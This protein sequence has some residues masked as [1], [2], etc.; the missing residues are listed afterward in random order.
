MA[1]SYFKLFVYGLFPIPVILLGLLI[2][3]LPRSVHKV[4]LKLTDSVLF[5]HPHPNLKISLYWICL[6]ISLFTMFTSYQSYDDKKFTYYNIKEHGGSSDT[7]L[8]KLLG[9]ERNVWIATTGTGLWFLLHRFRS[10]F[11]KL[12]LAEDSMK[13]QKSK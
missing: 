9:A 6:L 13:A 3:P 8:M 5:Y 10:M 7:A 1:M 11:K 12:I 2:F 4:V